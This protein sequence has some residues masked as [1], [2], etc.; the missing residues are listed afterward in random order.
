MPQTPCSTWASDPAVLSPAPKACRDFISAQGNQLLKLEEPLMSA[1]PQDP[2]VLE[3]FAGIR[4]DTATR[5]FTVEGPWRIDIESDSDFLLSEFRYGPSNR[6]S[7]IRLPKF[8]EPGKKS[9]SFK[10]GGTFYLNVRADGSWRAKISR[11][12]KVYLYDYDI[13]AS[14]ALVNPAPLPLLIRYSFGEGPQQ[15]IT[16]QPGQKMPIS[17]N[18]ALSDYSE[19]R[20]ATQLRED[21]PGLLIHRVVNVSKATVQARRQAQERARRSKLDP[22][23][24]KSDAR[25]ELQHTAI[26]VHS[27]RQRAEEAQEDSLKAQSRRKD[28]RWR[29]NWSA[30]GITTLIGGVGAGTA[31]MILGGTRLGPANEELKRVKAERDRM[32]E[33]P[34]P[35][36]LVEVGQRSRDVSNARNL[37]NTGIVVAAAGALIGAACLVIAKRPPSKRKSAG[38]VL[39]LNPAF[40][41]RF[42]GAGGSLRF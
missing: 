41:A 11:E 3:E 8:N 28:Q 19:E 6:E 42:V 2:E 24:S 21:F 18:I 15:E 27:D 26:G 7:V 31:L 33:D 29:R 22:S 14:S 36:I 4:G 30:A 38:Y 39:Q 12:A 32:G 1:V 23:N 5:T 17:G 9:K 37:L 13:A 34:S 10:R 40:G 35:N 25:S 16:L 20:S